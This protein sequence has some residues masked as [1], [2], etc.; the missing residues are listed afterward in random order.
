MLVQ[1]AWVIWNNA[2]SNDPLKRWTVTVAERRGKCVAIV[3]LARRLAGVLWAMWRDETYYDPL[4]LGKKIARGL[5]AKAAR[6]HAQSEGI[7]RS[8][9][10][11]MLR[12]RRNVKLSMVRTGGTMTT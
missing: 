6:A 9:K 5:D 12:Q 4:T 2:D 11:A 3:A 7:A 1:A 10:K 8:A